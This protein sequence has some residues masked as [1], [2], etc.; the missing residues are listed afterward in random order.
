M[1]RDETRSG[2]FDRPWTRARRLATTAILLGVTAGVMTLRGPARGGEERPTAEAGARPEASASAAAAASS[3][4]FYPHPGMSGVMVL[5]P[6]RA[7][8]HA[9]ME[10][11]LPALDEG[12]APGAKKLGIDPK[13]PGFLRLELK[14]IDWVTLGI[15]FGRTTRMKDEDGRPLHTV[16]VHTPAVRTFAP[17]DWLAFLRQWRLECSEVRDRGGVYYRLSGPVAEILGPNSCCYL[18][19]DRTIVYDN[20]DVIRKMAAGGM[21]ALPDF[22]HGP[23]WERACRGLVAVALDNR[24]GA[25]AKACDLD[26]RD[27][28]AALPL[29][30]GV[31]CWTFSLDDADAMVLR[32]WAACDTGGV[33]AVVDRTIET[34]VKQGLA[35]FDRDASKGPDGSNDL[36]ERMCLSLL[37]NLHVDHDDRSVGVQSDRF[38]TLSDLAS[39]VVGG[40][41]DSFKPEDP[42]ETSKAPKP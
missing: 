28:A 21:P 7:A 13:R 25:L 12:L 41:R 31:D 3:P 14:D 16:M 15:T 19:D 18:P 11:I 39:M 17:F 40:I 8:R 30:K 34:L 20:E 23:D 24:G 5:R 36:A 6:A 35:A 38:G 10:R 42:K 2:T 37:A 4:L 26:R 29:L 9:G 33:S 1:L 27:E 32:A 22:V